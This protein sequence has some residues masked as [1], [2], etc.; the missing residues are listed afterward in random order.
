MNL[1]I[2]FVEIKTKSLITKITVVINFY[3][4]E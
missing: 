4:N 2:P 3:K 1:I